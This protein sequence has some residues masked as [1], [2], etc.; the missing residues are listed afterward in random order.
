M[1]RYKE[2]LNAGQVVKGLYITSN[3]VKIVHFDP[4]PRAGNSTAKGVSAKDVQEAIKAGTA[5][6]E[7]LQ[8]GIERINAREKRA[9]E[10]D[11]EKVQQTLHEQFCKTYLQLEGNNGL[12]P[13][14]HLA[15][16]LLVY[17]SLNYQS[18][19]YVDE[20]LNAKIDGNSY[21]GTQQQLEALAGL[22]EQQFSV[23][24]RMAVVAK[25]ESKQPGHV[26]AVC[27]HQVALGAGLDIAT[28]EQQQQ[29]KTKERE[30]RL[31]VKI[32]DLQNRI[33]SMEPQQQQRA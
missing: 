22:T 4:S 14:D 23:L 17:Q 24:I 29:A 31:S 7:L 16:R 2:R 5:T 13:A 26:N 20:I 6:A 27:L 18:K 32:I 11:A 25:P 19:S 21:P 33:S 12:T 3:E 9:K 10:L 8:A 30:T 1:L 15:V 28:I